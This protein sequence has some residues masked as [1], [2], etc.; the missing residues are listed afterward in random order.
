MSKRGTAGHWPW[1]P[2]LVAAFNCLA[3][4]CCAG[5]SLPLAATPAQ[6]RTWSGWCTT[7]F[8]R[9]L[10]RQVGFAVLIL[11]GSMSSGLALGRVSE[12]RLRCL[13][14]ARQ[15]VHC[16]LH[17]NSNHAVAASR[18]QAR[19]RCKPGVILRKL[20]QELPANVVRPGLCA[21]LVFSCWQRF[22]RQ[23]PR[24]MVSSPPMC[25]LSA[26]AVHCARGSSWV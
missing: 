6:R 5:T 10:S 24:G 22:D 14:R 13:S 9:T 15:P 11:Q 4:P 23:R 19:D 16:G 8:W 21:E 25:A 20:Q 1:G 17:C 12:C 26:G 7:S 18:L 2:S 3:H